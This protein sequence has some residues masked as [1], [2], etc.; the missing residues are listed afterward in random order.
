MKKRIMIIGP[1]NSGKNELMS[2][3]EKKELRIWSDNLI[4]KD[5]SFLIPSSY[6]SSPWMYKHILSLQQQANLVIMML[7]EGKKKNTYPPNFAYL[8]HMPVIGVITRS[9]KES[10]HSDSLIKACQNELE[11]TGAF[12]QFIIDFQYQ[13]SLSALDE[14][15]STQEIQLSSSSLK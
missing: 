13:D 10:E 8:F 3:I 12:R 14:Y 4:F 11:E 1:K 9:D 15:L 6:I 5:K 2:H 7:G